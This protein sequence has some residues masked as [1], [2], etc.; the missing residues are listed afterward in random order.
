MRYRHLS[1][2]ALAIF[3]AISVVRAWDHE[4]HR[5]VSQLAL[6][7]LPKDFPDF[8]R[9]PANAGRVAFLANVPD[10][11]RNVDPWLRQSGGF[12]AAAQ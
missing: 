10:R 4:G 8:V 11:W 9:V 12:S 1:F 3:S 7:S 6:A 5:I 2:V